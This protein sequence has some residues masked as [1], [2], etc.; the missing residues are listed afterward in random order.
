MCSRT[1]AN[2]FIARGKEHEIEHGEIKQ[3]MGFLSKALDY[4]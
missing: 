2:G 4:P 1:C 3:E